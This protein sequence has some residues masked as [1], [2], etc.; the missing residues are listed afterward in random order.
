MKLITTQTINMLTKQ[1]QKTLFSVLLV[2]SL[3]SSV[4]LNMEA[5]E[6]NAQGFDV[7]Y[8]APEDAEIMFPDVEFVSLFLEKAKDILFV[9]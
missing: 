7:S 9:R 6:L 5:K 4:F 2:L 1:I 3:T 8:F